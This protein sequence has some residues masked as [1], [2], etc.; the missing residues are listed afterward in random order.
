M[1]DWREVER[2]KSSPED[3]HH[4][5]QRILSSYGTTLNDWERKFVGSLADKAP[6]SLTTRQAEKLIEIRDG[7]RGWRVVDGVS[8]ERLVRAC[9][10]NRLELGESDEQFFLTV[11]GRLPAVYTRA[12][13]I[14]IVRCA[15][16][17]GEIEPYQCRI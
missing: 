14:R 15:R 2:F 4:T 11:H 7:A 8:L 6:R 5:A 10:E 9:F 12:E 1:T 13:A 3:A 17:L 16:E